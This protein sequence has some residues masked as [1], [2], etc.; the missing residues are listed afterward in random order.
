MN[1]EL[2]PDLIRAVDPSRG[3][4]C[5][6]TY[7][8]PNPNDPNPEMPGLKHSIVS[9]IPVKPNAKCLCGS[10]K[11]FKKCCQLKGKWQ[12][13]C[14]NPGG[15]GFSL[16]VPQKAHFTSIDGSALKEKIMLDSRLVCFEDTVA[17]SFWVLW[18][19]PA[20]R[21]EFGV[22]CFGDIELQNN[23]T[24]LVTAMSDKRMS[25]LIALL[26]E[27]APFPLGKIRITKGELPSI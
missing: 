22:I 24:L 21:S 9:Y 11:T 15:K 12:P 25:V 5:W 2:S 17:R 27:V 20:I 16:V 1:L 13:V 18:G 19:N 6:S 14:A 23:H 10:K 8:N 3:M 7:W 26:Q 4:L